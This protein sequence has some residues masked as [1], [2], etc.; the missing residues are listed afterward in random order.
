[1]GGDVIRTPLILFLM[2]SYTCVQCKEGRLNDSAAGGDCR[3]SSR[4]RASRVAALAPQSLLSE[5][6]K[7]YLP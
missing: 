6:T 4:G 2:E 1:M 5:P 7:H 3:P